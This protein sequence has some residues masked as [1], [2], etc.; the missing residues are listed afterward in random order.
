MPKSRL[1]RVM[2]ALLWATG[3][4]TAFELWRRADVPLSE[5]PGVLADWLEDF[6][7]IKAAVLF[8]MLYSLRPL[9]FFPSVLF[10][11]ASGILFGPW[12]GITLTMLGENF[13]ANLAFAMTRLLGRRWIEKHETGFVQKLDANL[14]SNGLLSVA[15]FRLI[16]LPYDTVSYCCGLTSVSARDFACGT[17]LGS[18]PYLASIALMGGAASDHVTSA[19]VVLGVTISAKAILVWVSATLLVL[20]VLLAFRLRRSFR[21]LA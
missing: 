6:G 13:G 4:I 21:T 8:L 16:S 7:T 9:I 19:I 11:L 2:V 14:G 17:F 1:L 20:G 10:A 18:I 15:I 12:I 5:L 3:L